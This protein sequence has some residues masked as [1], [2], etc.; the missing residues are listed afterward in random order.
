MT[1]NPWQVKSIQA[2]SCLKCPECDFDTK[3]ENLFEYHATENHP[4]SL[5]LFDKECFKSE[6]YED[7]MK[8]EPT[9]DIYE[10]KNC[11]AEEIFLKD[12]VKEELIFD[13]CNYLEVSLTK[14]N[15]LNDISEIKKEITFADPLDINVI[16]N[17]NPDRFRKS[18]SYENLETNNLDTSHES[19]EVVQSSSL[20]EGNKHF[21]CEHCEYASTEKLCLARHIQVVHVQKTSQSVNFVN[22]H[23]LID[24]NWPD[25]Y[26]QYMK[27][28]NPL[29]VEFVN[30]HLL[31]KVL[32][33]N[34]LRLY[35]KERSPLSV[36]FV[37][38]HLLINV[39]WPDTFR[40]SMKEINPVS[41]N[42]V[43]LHLWK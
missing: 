9:D 22:M 29:S 21:K 8:S 17:S 13:A 3:E 6:A 18:Y 23:L 27:G 28:R 42:F 4:L 5:V 26:R 20:S 24:I 19:S 38:T 1:S 30:T 32:L 31:Q 10:L 15:S 37:N 33:I 14:E 43:D 11:N 40:V 7:T 34:I 39:A 12:F 41:V 25:T 16:V 36:N 2:F 35:M